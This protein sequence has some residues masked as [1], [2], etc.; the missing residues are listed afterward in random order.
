LDHLEAEGLHERRVKFSRQVS[1]WTGVD[2][3]AL[4]GAYEEAIEEIETRLMPVNEIL[5]GLPFGPGRDRLQINLRRAESKDIAQF[6]RELK[7]LAS[8]TTQ[9]RS[10]REIEARFSQM[11]R[12]IDRI[13]KSDKVA[14]REYLIDVRR[15]V[16]IDAER[17]DLQGRQ[18][19]VYTSIGGKSGGESQE[20]V[21]FIVGAALRYQLGDADLARPRY[22]PVFLDEGFVK[23]DAEFT[24]R[25]VRAW[26]VLGFQLIIGAPLD[27]VTGIEPYMDELYQVTKNSKKHS[28][29]RKIHPVTRASQ[30][31]HQA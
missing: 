16:E 23:S 12:F 20:L 11:K 8:D 19:S 4:H 15:H 1:D 6:R 22:A 7:I 14:Q 5:A 24:G 2:L 9:L 31:P 10:S 25:A 27:K 21:A 29:V 3:L 26:Q 30:E 13:R 17:R 28:H 18:L